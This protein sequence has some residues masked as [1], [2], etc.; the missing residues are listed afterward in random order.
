[1]SAISGIPPAGAGASPVA[2][3]SGLPPRLAAEVASGQ[4]TQAQAEAKVAEWKS[5]PHHGH[6]HGG[7]GGAQAVGLNGQPQVAAGGPPG[8]LSAVG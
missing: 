4:I 6:H 7:Q 2:N 5:H 1:M 3:T 8:G